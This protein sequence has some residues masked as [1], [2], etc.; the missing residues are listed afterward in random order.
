MFA[1]GECV[2]VVSVWIRDI[3]VVCDRYLDVCEYMLGN[4]ISVCCVLYV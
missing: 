1:S 4:Y 3:C 2:C